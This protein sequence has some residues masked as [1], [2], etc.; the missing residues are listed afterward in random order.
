MF[1]F[2]LL[3]CFLAL[4]AAFEVPMSRRAVMT[5]AATAAAATFAAA[6]AFADSDNRMYTLVARPEV[7][8]VTG[9]EVKAGKGN[10]D[11]KR[12]DANGAVL[13]PNTSFSSSKDAANFAKA[14]STVSSA[15]LVGGMG[16][17]NPTS[18]TR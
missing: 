10:Q 17:E 16:A 14:G 18:L 3:V 7:S 8:I 9:A 6:P 15:A 1:R 4:T 11:G 5:R 13:K 12:V 2:L